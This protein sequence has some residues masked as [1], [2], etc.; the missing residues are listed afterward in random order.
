MYCKYA[1]WSITCAISQQF[2]V[3]QMD[4]IIWILVHLLHYW[5]SRISQSR[6]IANNRKWWSVSQLGFLRL[7][8]DTMTMVAFTKRTFDWGDWLTASDYYRHD[9]ECSAIQTGCWSWVL[10]STGS[11]KSTEWHFEG[12]SSKRDF[13]DHHHSDTLPPA[14]I[15]T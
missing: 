11:K 6:P 4:V 15:H 10:L 12:R 1:K 13:K 3:I 2:P 7:W 5:C 14:R 8:R 9:G